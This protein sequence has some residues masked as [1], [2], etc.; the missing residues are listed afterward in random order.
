MGVFKGYQIE[1]INALTGVHFSTTSKF[2]NLTGN[3]T[4]EYPGVLTGNATSPILFFK[5]Y[6]TGSSFK[7]PEV[8]DEFQTSLPIKFQIADSLEEIEPTIWLEHQDNLTPVIS[9]SPNPTNGLINCTVK[10]NYSN[11]K[12]VLTNAAGD[13]LYEE[14]IINP[15]FSMDLSLYKSGNYYLLIQNSAGEL[16]Q[17]IKLIKL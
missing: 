5:M 15:N 1:W 6:R 3:L 16:I 17:T 4:L 8:Q 13:Y 14:R 2:S 10:G 9:V 12:W 11:L 7:S